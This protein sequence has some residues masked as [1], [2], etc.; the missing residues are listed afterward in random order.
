MAATKSQG[1]IEAAL[2]A[3]VVPGLTRVGWL[4][5]LWRAIFCPDDLNLRHVAG[6][7]ELHA[8]R[9]EES[10]RRTNGS[11]EEVEDTKSPV[12]AKLWHE[13]TG[14]ARTATWGRRWSPEAET[15]TSE[16]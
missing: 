12:F 1:R 2:M 4:G 8:Q 6:C 5:P 10:Q 15:Q 7:S 9:G 3:G 13:V 14:F 16:K 11:G